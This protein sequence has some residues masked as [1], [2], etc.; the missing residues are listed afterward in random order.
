MTQYEIHHSP[1]R[2]KRGLKPWGVFE[3]VAP[4]FKR[5]LSM[6]DTRQEAEAE[7]SKLQKKEGE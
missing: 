2:E 6:H 7:M 3:V 5:G 4:D 1:A